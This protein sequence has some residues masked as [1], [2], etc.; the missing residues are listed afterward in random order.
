[1]AI[2]SWAAASASPATWPGSPSTDYDNRPKVFWSYRR[3]CPA[4][5]R[6]SRAAGPPRAHTWAV[7]HA[8][9]VRLA[10]V[11]A[12]QDPP[13]VLVLDDLHLVTDAGHLG[14]PWTTCS[15]TRCRL[16]PGG[17]SRVDPLLPLHRYR[18]TGELGRDPGR[19][20]GLQRR[21]IRPA[22]GASGHHPVRGGDRGTHRADR[23]LGGGI[24]LAA[25]PGT[26]IPI[27]S[28]SSRNSR[29]KTV[30]SL[31][32]WSTRC[33]TPASPGARAAAA[34]PASWSASTRISPASSPMTPAPP[35]PGRPARGRT[36]SSGRSGTA[37]PATT[38]C[39]PSSPP[40]APDRG[41]RAAAGL[42]QRAARWYQRNG[43]LKKPCG[44]GS[45]IRQLAVRR[46]NSHGR[47]RGR[48]AHRPAREPA[49]GRSVQPHAARWRV[50]RP[51][52]VAGARRDRAV[53]PGAGGQQRRRL[54]TAESI[55]EPFPP[56][57]RSRHG[58][59]LP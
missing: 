22:P 42:Y 49:T 12:V 48:R 6:H 43:M 27:P 31:V 26:D 13:V 7:E 25:L 34:A 32:T 58:W 30:P 51:L 20:P 55:L 3:G 52:A 46:R 15:G 28:N 44:S 18:L 29:P 54:E 39:S 35:D 4:A 53:R 14:R 5:S 16:A 40:Q 17:S 47:V 41:R 50:G 21:G 38:R 1:M 33:S 45:R 56:P 10:S 8:F 2:A 11:L 59:A 24:R 36:P 57:I 37:G 19:R 23:R 9:L